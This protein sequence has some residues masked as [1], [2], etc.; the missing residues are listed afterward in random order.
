MFWKAAHSFCSSAGIMNLQLRNLQPPPGDISSLVLLAKS[1]RL[2]PGP[3]PFVFSQTLLLI[4][5]IAKNHTT[6]TYFC[7]PKWSS[8]PSTVPALQPIQSIHHPSSPLFCFRWMDY[9]LSRKRS[10]PTPFHPFKP[11]SLLLAAVD[12]SPPNISANYYKLF[13]SNLLFGLYSIALSASI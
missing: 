1:S 9:R 13:S 3:E 10:Q 6:K 12:T 2:S 11:F 7:Q 5:T 8:H 4:D